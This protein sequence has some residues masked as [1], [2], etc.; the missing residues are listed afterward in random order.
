[1]TGVSFK[2]RQGVGKKIIA[3]E[4]AEGIIQHSLLHNA[5]S[6]VRIVLCLII[7]YME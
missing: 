7:Q 1:M 2:R 6:E 4:E 3:L 5:I